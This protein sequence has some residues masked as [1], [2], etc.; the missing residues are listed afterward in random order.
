MKKSTICDGLETSQ[1]EHQIT[2][3]DYAGTVKQIIKCIV[4]YI[5][6]FGSYY[7]LRKC[8]SCAHLKLMEDKRHRIIVTQKIGNFHS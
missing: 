1:R 7:L 4:I 6:V 2:F 8:R 5:S 3:N